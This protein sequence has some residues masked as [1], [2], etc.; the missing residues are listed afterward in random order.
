MGCFGEGYVPPGIADAWFME[1]RR[2]RVL[3]SLIEAPSGHDVAGQKQRRGLHGRF[4]LPDIQKMSCEP[5][6]AC[7]VRRGTGRRSGPHGE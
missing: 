4:R 5:A 7:F 3:H 6:A 2:A 1:R